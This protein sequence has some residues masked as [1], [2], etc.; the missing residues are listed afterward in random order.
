M[1][2]PVLVGVDGSTTSMAA[3]EV[4]AR[5]A[6]RM[7]VELRLAHACAWPSATVTPGVA[8]W[9]PGGT[10]GHGAANRALAE[11]ERRARR[12]A[13]CLRVTYTVLMGEPAAVLET[14]SHGASLTVVGSRP[15]GRS[16]GARRGSVA[17]RLA[18]HGGSPV[19][20]V[21]GGPDPA[22]PVV[23]ACDDGHVRRH[24]AEFAFGEAAV[25]GTDVL[26]LDGFAAR[27]G[28]IQ[29]RP[30]DP[31]AALRERYPDITVRRARVRGG[32]RR[33]VVEASGFAQL[34]VIGARCRGGWSAALPPTVSRAALRHAGCPVA[35][36]P[37]EEE[38][39]RQVRRRPDGRHWQR[40]RR[41]P[42]GLFG[43]F[44][45]F[46]SKAGK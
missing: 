3:V 9:D 8:P 30:H 1:S 35:V 42:L 46:S 31:L 33:A 5:E 19:L 12:V 37:E 28:R 39:L 21:R 40:Q 36:I 23:L 27:S 43:L 11:A 25:R 15:A 38:T 44:G 22:G 17:A 32:T 16:G 45:P 13:P 29:D 4:A 10:R 41:S 20:M 24:A 18:G 34:V 14:E 2:G 7:G 6:D 26:V